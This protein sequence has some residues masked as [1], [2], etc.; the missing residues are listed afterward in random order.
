LTGLVGG[1]PLAQKIAAAPAV[2]M[3][4]VARR[5]GA[6]LIAQLEASD[7]ERDAIVAASRDFGVLSKFTSLLVLENDEAYKK[8]DIERKQQQLL[9]QAAPQITGGDLDTLGVRRANLTP[10]EIQPGDPEV[11]VP[12][13]ADARLVLVSFPFG[14]TKRAVWDPEVDAW[15][16]RFLIDKDT[17]DGA[18]TARVTITHADGHVQVMALPYL[19]DTHAPTLRLTATRVDG[20]YRI[21]ARQTDGGA[22]RRDAERLE[23]QLPD[24]TILALAQRAWGRFEAVWQTAPLDHAVTLRVVVHDH[25]LNTATAELAIPSAGAAP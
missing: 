9:A 5:F 1:A 10:D 6:D 11:K 24:G 12:A 13:P 20:G 17:P 19:V 3:P 16:V 7:A 2:A 23:V 21:T 14:E 22:G 18:Y 8:Y 25:A 15:M 4:G